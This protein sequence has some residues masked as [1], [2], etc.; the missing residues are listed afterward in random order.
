LDDW[1]GAAMGEKKWLR[2]GQDYLLGC[3]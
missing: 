1:G 3:C 2:G